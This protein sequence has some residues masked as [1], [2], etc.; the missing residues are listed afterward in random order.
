MYF[1][2]SIFGLWK[3][4]FETF[5]ILAIP[6]QIGINGCRLENGNEHEIPSSH[7]T[8]K[9]PTTYTQ[10]FI[11]D[12]EIIQVFAFSP[13]FAKLKA[14]WLFLRLTNTRL[15]YIYINLFIFPD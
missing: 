5:I 2:M 7:A 8:R 11:S 14:I 15:R 10:F 12:L 6:G 4:E 9:K 13:I 1:L 3:S